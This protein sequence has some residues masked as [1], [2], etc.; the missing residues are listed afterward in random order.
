MIAF[1]RGIR[2]LVVAGL[3]VLPAGAGAAP[4]AGYVAYRDP[5]GFVLERPPGWTVDAP[6]VGQVTV[7]D[8]S[9]RAVAMIRGRVARGDLA[10]W[11]AQGFPAG[12]PWIASTTVLATE[13]VA[14]ETARAA[15][16]FADANGAR[17]RAN[18]IAVRRG[19]IATVFV[20]A[21]HEDAFAQALPDLAAILDSFRFV[22]PPASGGA[23]PQL[24][25][26]QW[27]DP[28]E[29]A[30]ATDIPRGWVPSGGM[31]RRGLAGAKPIL[32]VRSPDG[33]I[34]LYL[35]DGSIPRFIVPS[36]LIT[37]LGYREGAV[38][39][40]SGSVISR[41]R[42][43]GEIG[44]DVVQGRFGRV[45][46]LDRR[47]R[48]D[49]VELRR[50]MQ[51]VLQ[52]SITQMT[53]ADIDFRTGDG[54]LGTLTI[55]NSGWELPNLSGGWSVD[56]VYGFLAPPEATAVAG[57]ALGRLLGAFRVNPDWF[58]QELGAQAQAQQ[59]YMAY[60]Q[61]S[62]A[63]Q[64]QTVSQRWATQ[65]RQGREWRD[66]LT[67]TVRLV[68]PQTNETFEVQGGSRYFF[69]NPNPQRPAVVG[70]DVDSNPDP[71]EMRR[72]LQ[73]GVDT[74]YR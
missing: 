49:L 20:A 72:L 74:P 4:P 46:L 70:V 73:M 5:A 32:G 69:R 62:A 35:G 29:N 30:F 14:G 9:R 33:R 51:P 36:Q 19:E 23:P 48:P 27:V 25:F 26:V 34:E 53:G 56:D 44:G 18:A 59:Q 7:A 38:E 13:N 12:E 58:R 67:N 10:A 8:P 16:R 31:V 63:L 17:I 71:I 55:T 68:D 37:G 60:F 54:R 65:D 43:A 1:V 6:S 64:Q 41:F 21:A 40:S 47:D 52:G 61:Q 39:P 66:A 2:C 11:L 57:A 45:T 42:H 24:D 3:A 15:F 50:R 28:L 22:V